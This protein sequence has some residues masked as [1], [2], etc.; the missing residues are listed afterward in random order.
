MHATLGLSQNRGQ[1][2][3]AGRGHFLNSSLQRGRVVRVRVKVRVKVR[4]KLSVRVRVRVN[5]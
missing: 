5:S 3:P 2:A 4:I 1:I